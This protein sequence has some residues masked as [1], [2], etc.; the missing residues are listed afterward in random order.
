MEHL[1][2]VILWLHGF[3]VSWV[4]LFFCS[5]TYG[6]GIYGWVL[7]ILGGLFLT[8]VRVGMSHLHKRVGCLLH[9]RFIAR[10]SVGLLE[11]SLGI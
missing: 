5:P 10:V 6:M 1:I 9:N 4:F 8:A 7:G 2:V 11:H 3:M